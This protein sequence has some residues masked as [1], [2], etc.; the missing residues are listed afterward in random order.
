L[1]LKPIPGIKNN[2]DFYSL[3]LLIKYN[4]FQ[5]YTHNF[6]NFYGIFKEKY[7]ARLDGCAITKCIRRN[8]KMF[9]IKLQYNLTD[10][11]K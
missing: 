7:I 11:R 10:N 6:S 9:D 3:L 2:M 4:G 5:V 8:G 1:A